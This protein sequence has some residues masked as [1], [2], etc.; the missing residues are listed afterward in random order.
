[1]MRTFCAVAQDPTADAKLAS[2]GELF[3]RAKH[4]SFKQIHALKRPVAEVKK[5][6][7]VRFGITA[8]H[9]NGI[10]FDLDQAVNAWRGSVES[11]IS[12]LEDAIEATKKRIATFDKPMAE[13]RTEKRRKYLRFKQVGKKRRLDVLN[14]RLGVAKAELKAATPRVCFGGRE[15]LRDMG[16]DEG[17]IWRWRDRR[18]GRINFVGAACEA[19]GNQSC[20]WDG[21]DLRIRLPD[22]LGGG[23]VTITGVTF[24]YGQQEMLRI[25]ERNKDKATRTGI[26]WMLFRDDEGRWNVRATVDEEPATVLTDIRRGAIGVDVNVDHLAVVITDRHG[27]PTGRLKLPFPDADT[28]SDKASAMIGE[29]CKALSLLALKHGYGIAVEDLEFSRKKA[30][31]REFGADHARRL[32]GF[33]YSKFRQMIQARCARDGVELVQVDP[34]Y[35]SQ[36]GRR[37]YACWRAMSVHESAALVIARAA[38][39][40]GERLVTMDGTALDAPGRM[41]PRTE[42]RRWRGAQ[43]LTRE[44]AQ[45]AARTARSGTGKTTRKQGRPSRPASGGAAQGPSPSRIAGARSRRVPSQVGGAVAPASD[46]VSRHG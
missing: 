6:A 18:S 39:G 32:S 2:L 25:L 43:P 9:F 11:R 41:R 28:S 31:L 33:A 14:G 37:K 40:H 36:I 5:E 45:A 10:R 21:K 19:E 7:I 4:W 38:R 35:T 8:R 42:R 34:A 24:R 26:T 3:G 27:N 15:L 13:A 29:A 30:S 20:R 17:A 44:G 12:Q 23:F 1:M 16:S 22:A 46:T